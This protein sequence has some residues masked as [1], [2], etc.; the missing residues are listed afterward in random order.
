MASACKDTEQVML[1]SPDGKQTIRAFHEECSTYRDYTV[2]LSSGLTGFGVPRYISIAEFYDVGPGQ[3]SVAWNG[4]SEVDITYPKS[5]KIGN[6]SAKMRGVRI[7]LKP[8][9]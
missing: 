2:E 4:S 1:K 8:P 6:V 5:A 9:L 7:V 3:V